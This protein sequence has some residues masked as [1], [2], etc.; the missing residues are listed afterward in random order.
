MHVEFILAN[1]RRV[2]EEVRAEREPSVSQGAVTATR[3]ITNEHALI[4]AYLDA[5]DE[6]FAA[7]FPKFD[8]RDDCSIR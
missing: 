7:R 2:Y 8:D 5:R 6:P 1:E 4:A 3:L